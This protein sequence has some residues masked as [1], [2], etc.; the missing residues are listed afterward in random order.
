MRRASRK[1]CWPSTTVEPGV[2]QRPQDGHF[3]DVDPDRLARE[4]VLGQ[5]GGDLAG[6]L[7]GDAG[8]G[9][10]GATQGG[11]AGAGPVRAVEPRVVELVVA[12]GGTEVP[13]DGLATAG[14]EGEADELVHGPGADVG[15]RHVADV[16]EVEGE[17][18]AEIG[19]LE[20]VV[21]A[22]QA[23][24]P[25][26]TEVDPLFPVDGVGTVG[27]DSHCRSPHSA[28]PT[29]VEHRD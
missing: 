13:D 19:A 4:A 20:G 28:R 9:V 5:L 10:E 16:G 7:L 3:D 2:G 27:P 24:L 18:G 23:L 8:V 14:Q 6:D 25:E 11:D 17:Q 29:K 26:P 1:T 22:A 21:E 15:G 12:G